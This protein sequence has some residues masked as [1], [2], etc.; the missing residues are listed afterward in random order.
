MAPRARKGEA[1]RTVAF[2]TLA[3]EVSATGTTYDLPACDWQTWLEAIRKRPLE[4]R[5]HDSGDRR[6][7]GEILTVDTDLALKLMEPRSE[8]SWLELLSLD[9]AGGA[10]TQAFDSARLGELVETSVVAFLPDKNRFGI[11]RGSTSAPTFAAVAEWVDHMTVDGKHLVSD[12]HVVRA[13]AVVARKQAAKLKHADGAGMTSVRV[14]TSQASAVEEVGSLLAG[15]LR[16]LHD[17]YGDIVVTVTMKIPRGKDNDEARSK[18]KAET[19]RLRSLGDRV[20]SLKASLVTYDANAQAHLEEVDFVTQ[21]ITT[22]TV[23]PVKGENGE[24]IKNESAVRAILRAANDL[25]DQM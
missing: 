7:I 6:L 20:Q 18:L 9:R 8:D 23:V 15:T 19:D 14:A 4:E 3:G 1:V 13:Q 25:R 12:G 24:P 16:S 17:T 2:F 10:T 21:R 22:K 5:T 11:I